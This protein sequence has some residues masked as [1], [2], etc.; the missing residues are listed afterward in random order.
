MVELE[1]TDG[2]FQLFEVASNQEVAPD[3]NQGATKQPRLIQH[4]LHHPILV[5]V[6]GVQSQRLE[7]GTL[8]GEDVGH[9]PALSQAPQLSLGQGLLEEVPFHQLRA[10]L[11]KI[12]F[13]F[14][15]GRSTG[16]PVELDSTKHVHLRSW[17][18]ADLPEHL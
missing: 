7:A 6:I 5:Q 8:P 4:Q 11:R 2:T 13:R 3:S 1:L 10:F 9:L 12:L 17:S 16:P 14:A 18:R 15:A